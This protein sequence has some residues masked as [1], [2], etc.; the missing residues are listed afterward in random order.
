M[1]LYN[2]G[3]YIRHYPISYK[4]RLFF[5]RRGFILYFVNFYQ[6]TNLTCYNVSRR[7]IVEK[8]KG[9]LYVRDDVLYRSVHQKLLRADSP[10]LASSGFI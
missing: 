5:F 4:P 10:R 2:K 1:E 6:L 7:Q 9:K 3:D 8:I